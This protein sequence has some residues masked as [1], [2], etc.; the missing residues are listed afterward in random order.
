MTIVNDGVSPAIAWRERPM[1]AARPF[2]G[3]GMSSASRRFAMGRGKC[4]ELRNA[5]F[6]L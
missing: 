2:F 6:H 1:D 3:A 5:L 4:E